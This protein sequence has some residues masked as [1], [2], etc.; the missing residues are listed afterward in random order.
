MSDGQMSPDRAELEKLLGK[1][2][3]E[4]L[5]LLAQ[6]DPEHAETMFSSDEARD[7]GRRRFEQLSAPLRRRICDEWR[8]CEKKANGDLTDH[9]EIAV[10]V[11]DLITT[12]VGG[13][14]VA[15]VTAL[16]MKRGLN[17]LCGCGASS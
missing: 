10:T 1:D 6:S 8:Y 14:P 2:I 13:L 12:V 16:V 5:V 7:A 3:D 9:V 4:L 15:L 11:A 17:Q